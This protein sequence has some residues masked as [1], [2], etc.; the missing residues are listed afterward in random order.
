MENNPVSGTAA[1]ADPIS[2]KDSA[3]GLFRRIGFLGPGF[4][5]ILTAL[6]AGDIVSNTAAGAGYGYQLIWALAMTLV[7]RFV[8]VNVSAKYVLVTGES[9][10]TGYGRVGRWLPWLFLIS[11]V[12][13][14]HLANMYAI[15]MIG[16]SAD[17]LFPLP[18]EW[19]TAIWAFLFA[20][21]GFSMTYWGGYPM[22]E[23]FCKVLVGLM[24][25][26]LMVA[27]VLSRPDPA[28]I[29]GGTF[30]PTV[31]QAQGLYSAVL[32]MLALIGTEVGSSTNM[33]Y[34][35]FIYEK[36]WR[37][38][39]CLKQQR[40]DLLVG[41]VAMFIMGSLLQISAAGIIHPLGIDVED[42]EDLGRVFSDT[43]GVVG[44]IVF[45]LGLWGASF[46]TFVCGNT[47]GSLIFTDVCRT[48]VPGLR[49]AEKK[50]E[51]YSAGNDPVYRSILIFWAF[52]PMYILLTN[53]RPVLLVL[54][55]SSFYVALIPVLA[56][57]LV[58]ITSDKSLM[59]RYVNGWFTNAIMLLLV[60]V[61]IYFT[62]VQ[63]VD[64]FKRWMGWFPQ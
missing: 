44:T 8:W 3:P 54:I 36:G 27:A 41:I 16:S 35:Y 22:V 53:V 38:I 20:F 40:I 37:D 45:G 33:Y 32:I 7:F 63:L 49:T 61:S 50:K 46:S 18:T 52:S 5:Y 4:V 29:L 42:A 26:S 6:G 30:I 48:F 1:S 51:E 23:S 21:V 47:G 15:L 11:L 62:C 28:A 56:L 13:M 43:L 34:A 55:A 64:Y 31:P 19:S 12:P 60:F 39:S 57:S 17:L 24:G 58:K 10:L 9:L 59:G 14:R 2:S 25:G